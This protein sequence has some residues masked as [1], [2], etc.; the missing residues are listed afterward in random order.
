MSLQNVVVIGWLIAAFTCVTCAVWAMRRWVRARDDRRCVQCGYMLRSAN[1]RC[2][3]C[4]TRNT[5]HYRASRSRKSLIA[6]FTAIVCATVSFTG[7]VVFMVPT[8]QA[9][10]LLPT[11]CL[12]R[13]FSCNVVPMD[14]RDDVWHVLVSRR[15]ITVRDARVLGRWAIANLYRD[16]FETRRFELSVG[17]LLA[18]RLD[19]LRGV[20]L[21]TNYD[22]LIACVVQR[23]PISPSEYL[24][25]S[26]ISVLKQDELEEL[27][28]AAIAVRAYR[29][30]YSKDHYDVES[31]LML[32]ILDCSHE[33]VQLWLDS[34]TEQSDAVPSGW[35]ALR[36]FMPIP[37]LLELLRIGSIRSDAARLCIQLCLSA[38]A[39]REQETFI[40]LKWVIADLD[41]E[42]QARLLPAIQYGQSMSLRTKHAYYCVLGASV[43]RLASDNKRVP[44]M[45]E[46]KIAAFVIV[47]PSMRVNVIESVAIIVIDL[48]QL[49]PYGTVGM[50]VDCAARC[51]R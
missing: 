42:C 46:L 14:V 24:R 6:L 21:R 45:K 2:S 17:I 13:L 29:S 41:I 20:A 23:S 49:S 12:A 36:K 35:F 37:V 18:S 1:E 47:P 34:M 33:H 11:N 43:S 30:V 25:S 9:L 31:L 15:D 50:I 48:L 8:P 44:S 27:A 22:A 10:S 38:D 16:T 32:S 3:E 7:A 5:I 40:E 39:W 51:H 4:G 26:V 19:E 28:R